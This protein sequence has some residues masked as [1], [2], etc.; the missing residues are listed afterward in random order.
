MGKNHRHKKQ[1][2]SER[3]KVK[4]KGSKTK[5]LPKGQNVTNTNFKI[6]QIVIQEQLKVKSSGKA[7]DVKNIKV[8]PAYCVEHFV[9]AMFCCTGNFKLCETQQFEHKAR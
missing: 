7:L 4:L 6:K 3:A 2:K 8:R 5:F 1:L 9:G